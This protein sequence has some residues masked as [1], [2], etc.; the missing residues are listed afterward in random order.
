MATSLS[1]HDERVTGG[2]PDVQARFFNH[3]IRWG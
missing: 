2:G 3:P 1:A